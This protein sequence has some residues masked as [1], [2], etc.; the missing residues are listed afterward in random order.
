MRLVVGIAMLA[1]VGCRSSTTF[2]FEDA[3]VAVDAPAHIGAGPGGGLL[4]DLRF[5]IV[6][7]TRPTL[8]DDTANYPTAVVTTIWTAVQATQPQFAVAT[9]DYM[10]ASTTGSEQIPQLDL[11][12]GARANYSGVLYPA[13]GNH[14]CTA[15][16]ESNCGPGNADGE[17][18]NYH[19]FVDR[20]LAPIGE[21]KPYFIE[22]FAA[23]DGSWSAK[24]VFVAANAWTDLQ[25][26]WLDAVLG[27]PTTYT[28]VVRHE[29]HEAT[30]A[31]GVTPSNTIMAKHP[32]TLSIVGHVH[33]Y[34]HDP[35]DQE[36]LVG[37][38][39]APLSTAFG[40]GYVIV[41]RQPDGSLQVTAYDYATN[42]VIDQFA[43]AA[44]G[45]PR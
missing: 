17:P 3:Y 24:F 37:T 34:R 42:A 1:V 15:D 7:D 18:A 4:D 38:G 21:T 28:F 23:T 27:Q 45:T 32:L 8:P 5:A 25:G 43:I 13:Y 41:G 35:D 36:L 40:Y 33:P 14:E 39:G 9:G 10:F 2:A 12:L 22:R 26:D 44:D 30:A 20:L 31:P 29:P 19:A 16:T 6:G 11:Y